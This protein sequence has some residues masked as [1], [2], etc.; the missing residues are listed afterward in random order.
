M[1]ST[2]IPSLSAAA[3]HSKVANHRRAICGLYRRSL[4]NAFDWILNRDYHRQWCVAIRR[5]FDQHR[6]ESDPQ[7]IQE[8]MK[9]TEYLLWKYRH[10]EPYICKS[11]RIILIIGISYFFFSPLDPTAPGGVAYER[12]PV[13]DKD[14]LLTN[15][16]IFNYMCYTLHYYCI[17]LRRKRDSYGRKIRNL[18]LTQLGDKVKYN[19]CITYFIR[20]VVVL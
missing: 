20:I 7:R 8:L 14:V 2:I 12:D 6:E 10:P 4:R 11:N 17:V 3:A 19:I 15:G 5:K 1:S 18:I 9:A 13:F 16:I